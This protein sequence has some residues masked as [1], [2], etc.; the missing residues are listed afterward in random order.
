LEIA[1]LIHTDTGERDGNKRQAS[2]AVIDLLG[3]TVYG[4]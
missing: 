2:Q 4:T 1:E 3:K